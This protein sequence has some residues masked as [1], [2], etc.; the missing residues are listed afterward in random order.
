MFKTETMAAILGVGFS[1]DESMLVD[2]S[3]YTHTAAYGGAGDLVP[4]FEAD[5]NAQNLSRVPRSFEGISLPKNSAGGAEFG[6][7]IRGLAAL[8]KDSNIG[9]SFGQQDRINMQTAIK[10]AV[11]K[12][13][14]KGPQ[15][16]RV[17]TASALALASSNT[18]RVTKPSGAKPKKPRRV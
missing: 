10:S 17:P 13:S 18:D 11:A 4:A 12:S 16:P 9:K 6:L 14:K 3:E 2:E 7:K 8:N 5:K 1:P 15:G